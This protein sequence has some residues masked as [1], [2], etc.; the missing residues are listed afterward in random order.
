[1]FISP[2]ISF[3]FFRVKPPISALLLVVSLSCA[4]Q[5][6]VLLYFPLRKSFGCCRYL[7]TGYEPCFEGVVASS[8]N[9]EGR[10]EVAEPIYSENTRENAHILSHLA[11]NR[12]KSVLS[13]VMPPSSFDTTSGGSAFER[14]VYPAWAM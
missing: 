9:P 4:H 6:I 8:Y 12:P 11:I 1:V 7:K 5:S 2:A 13:N 10:R 14:V 3:F